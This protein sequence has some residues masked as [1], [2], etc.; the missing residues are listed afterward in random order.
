VKIYDFPMPSKCA[1]LDF[2]MAIQEKT[3]RPT[4][5]GHP[6]PILLNSFTHQNWVAALEVSVRDFLWLT[7]TA[8]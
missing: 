4:G 2:I 5:T 3:P 8:E 7:L 1:G 6:T